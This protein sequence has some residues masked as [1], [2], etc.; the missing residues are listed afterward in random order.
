MTD[1]VGEICFI[2]GSSY[3]LSERVKAAGAL[4]LSLSP[5]TFPHQLAKVMLYETVYRTVSIIS[6]TKYHK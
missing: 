5:L 1:G 6:G 4:R 3:G 2:I